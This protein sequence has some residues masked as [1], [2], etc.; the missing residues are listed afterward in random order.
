MMP[1]CR[2]LE[3]LRSLHAAG[4]LEG[5]EASRVA[6]HLEACAE[7]READAR[8]RD[9]LGLARLPAPSQAEA[10]AVADLAGDTLRELRRR[11][12]RLTWLRRAGTAAAVVAAAAA[13]VLLLL[14]PAVTRRP[15]PDG[16]P[17][18][19]AEATTATQDDGAAWDLDD[20]D[21]DDDGSWGSGS[22]STS[23]SNSM[24]D[25]ALA[26]YDAGVGN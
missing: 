2:E 20:L 26:A 22:D 21:A 7:C 19:V 13:A 12:R 25:V 14:G 3:V 1:E 17:T 6:A 16:G 24:T 4:A 8:D 23:T 10:L 18:Q 15:P 5:E 9:L 11:E